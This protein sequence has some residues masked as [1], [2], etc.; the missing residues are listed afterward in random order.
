MRR[1]RREGFTLIEVLVALALIGLSASMLAGFLAPR[2]LAA[3]LAAFDTDLQV[4]F[5]EASLAARRLG[6]SVVLR[7]NGV[8]RRVEGSEIDALMIPPDLSLSFV[9]A[10]EVRS[11][12]HAAIV[13]FPDGTNSGVDY[14]I[15]LGAERR[16]GRLSWLGGRAEV[17]P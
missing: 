17:G 1:S 14:H 3:R 2:G 15:G 12:G 6:R 5:V 4:R 9:T 7:L 8:S 13:F 16:I 11:D 10:R